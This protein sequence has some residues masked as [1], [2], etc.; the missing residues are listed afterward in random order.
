MGIITVH[1]SCTVSY[2]QDIKYAH[3]CVEETHKC[4]MPIKQ[5]WRNVNIQKYWHGKIT[6]QELRSQMVFDMEQVF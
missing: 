2:I 6:D 3:A 5:D 4:K 1:E